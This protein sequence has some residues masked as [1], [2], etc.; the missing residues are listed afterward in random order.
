MEFLFFSFAELIDTMNKY[1][2]I[3]NHHIPQKSL[4]HTSPIDAMKKWQQNHPD[5]FKKKVYKQAEPDS[6]V[7]QHLGS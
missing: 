7:T 4:N 3:Y 2:K 5:L 1:A 6:Y